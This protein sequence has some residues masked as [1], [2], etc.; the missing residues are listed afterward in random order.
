MGKERSLKKEELIAILGAVLIILG[1][2]ADWLGVGLS[3]G[4]GPVQSL[5]VAVGVVM[6]YHK[7]SCK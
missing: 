3:P 1:M 6:V 4:F 5:M 7:I 2:G